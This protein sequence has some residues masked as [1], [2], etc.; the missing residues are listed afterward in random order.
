MPILF[1]Q[2]LVGIGFGLL[3]TVIGLFVGN[4]I[5]FDSILISAIFG[6]MCYCIWHVHPA[7]CLI[8][9]A[10]TCLIFFGI[11]HTTI[12]FWAT[13][14]FLSFCWGAVFAVIAYFVTGSSLL[15]FSGVLIF[16]F[17]IMLLLHFKAN[18]KKM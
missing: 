18:K 13:A 5:L 8:I 10:V 17:V 4:I 6:Y 16:A 1:L 2:V 14:I 7:V 12:G 11:Q 15:W 9:A 3:M